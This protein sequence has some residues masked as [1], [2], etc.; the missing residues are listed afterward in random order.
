MALNGVA[1]EIS[2]QS[3]TKAPVRRPGWQALSCDTNSGD[4][5]VMPFNVR[6]RYSFTI[7][8]P[9]KI[10]VSF[11]NLFLVILYFTVTKQYLNLLNNDHVALYF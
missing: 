2:S 3:Q 5:L 8:S 7:F 10:V 4:R 9:P 1:G 11:G 6:R